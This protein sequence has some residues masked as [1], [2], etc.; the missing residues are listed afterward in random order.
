M[1]RI[2]YSYP[3]GTKFYQWEITTDRHYISD[4]EIEVSVLLNGSIPYGNQMKFTF[5]RLF[6]SMQTKQEGNKTFYINNWLLQFEPMDITSY[7]NIGI[8]WEYE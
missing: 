4:E 5:P 3:N 2:E 7:Y 8:G 1:D 6:E